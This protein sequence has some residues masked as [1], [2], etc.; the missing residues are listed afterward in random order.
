MV[1]DEELSR[2]IESLFNDD[3]PDHN[4][5]PNPRAFTTL[6][7]VVQELESKLGLDLS[8][9]VDF[10]RVQIQLLFRSYIPTPPQPLPRDY[11]ALHQNPNFHPGPSPVSSAFQSF[12]AQPVPQQPVK[13]EPAAAVAEAPTVRFVSLFLFGNFYFFCRFCSFLF[14]YRE[15]RGK[16]KEDETSRTVF[17]GD[18]KFGNIVNSASKT[19]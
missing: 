13:P 5:N 17:Y 7:G 4:A 12:S 14:G 6:N 19:R 16:R 3:N 11:F 8:H 15:N 18:F 10:I 9:K 2:A 1:T